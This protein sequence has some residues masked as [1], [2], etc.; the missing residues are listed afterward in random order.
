M[1]KPVSFVLD[2]FSIGQTNGL[3]TLTNPVT[4]LNEPVSEFQLVVE[5]FD[6]GDPSRSSNVTVVVTVGD[7][8]DR[9]PVFLSPSPG[10]PLQLPEV[11]L[12]EMPTSKILSYLVR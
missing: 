10:E 11:S 1:Y 6:H 7:E 8:N 4:S 2:I 5:A 3:L 12:A 9:A